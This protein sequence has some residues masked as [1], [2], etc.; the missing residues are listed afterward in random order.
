MWDLKAAAFRPGRPEDRVSLSTGYD[1]VQGEDADAAAQ[2]AAYWAT[3]HPDA[4]QRDYV[5]RMFARQLFGDHG[6]E[7]FHIHAGFRASASNGKSRF[8][9]ILDASLGTPCLA[10]KRVKSR[11]GNPNIF[12]VFTGFR[13]R[14]TI[15]AFDPLDK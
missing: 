4:G 1:Y 12:N 15:L 9:E 5:M 14:Q 2:V 6:K 13:I 10:Q 3:M 11:F 8:F 7:L